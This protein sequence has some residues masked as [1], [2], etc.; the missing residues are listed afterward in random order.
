VRSYNIRQPVP[1]IAVSEGQH[2]E[3]P[4][5]LIKDKRIDQQENEKLTESWPIYQGSFVVGCDSLWSSRIDDS[6]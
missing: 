1:R 3:V 6:R 5:Y 4:I 2:L